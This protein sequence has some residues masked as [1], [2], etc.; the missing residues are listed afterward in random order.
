MGHCAGAEQGA[1]GADTKIT[2][3][4]PGQAG[5][6]MASGGET[7]VSSR[8][9][10]NAT[11]ELAG[12]AAP[13]MLPGGAEGGAAG[14]PN[15]PKKPNTVHQLQ[16]EIETLKARIGVDRERIKEGKD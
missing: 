11:G 10:P 3:G 5:S 2:T 1:P 12:A 4:R 7:R 8:R 14:G 13:V 9:L 6:N 15:D 16:Y